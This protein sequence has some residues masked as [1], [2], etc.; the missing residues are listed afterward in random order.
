MTQPAAHAPVV[1]YTPTIMDGAVV[2][3]YGDLNAAETGHEMMSASCNGVRIRCYLHEVPEKALTSATSI[4]ERL[5]AESERPFGR[6]ANSDADDAARALA[7]HRRR[8]LGRNGGL[9]PIN[10]AGANG[11]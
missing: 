8:G 1:I 10:R 4:A 7:T 3:W 9:E 2:R 6:R 5:R 11:G